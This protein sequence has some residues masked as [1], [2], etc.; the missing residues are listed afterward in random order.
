MLVEGRIEF[1]NHV[2][3]RSMRFACFGKCEG[4]QPLSGCKVPPSALRCRCP[5]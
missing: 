3:H 5:S 2:Y 1:L 4:V